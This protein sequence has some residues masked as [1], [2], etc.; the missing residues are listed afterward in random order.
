MKLFSMQR[1]PFV[2]HTLNFFYIFRLQ[3]AVLKHL[4]LSHLLTVKDMVLVPCKTIQ[5]VTQLLYQLLHIYKIYKIYTLK[6]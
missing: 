2:R 1:P 3:Q 6:H 5:K 4:K